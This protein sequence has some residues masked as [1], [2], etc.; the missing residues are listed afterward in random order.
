MKEVKQPSKKPLIYYY[1]I[2]LVVLMLL[3]ILLFP[4]VL[5]RQVTEVYYSDFLDMLEAHD[6]GL[7]E[8]ED[9]QIIF[10]NKDE[11]RIYKTGLWDDPDLTQR[12]QNSGVKFDKEIVTQAS[13]LLSFLVSWILPILIFVASSC[14]AGWPKAWG[15]PGG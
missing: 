15:T 6:V 10:T 5:E 13:P 7:V 11:S 3:N 4:S 2:A 12:L 1:V 14:P 9:N 8:M